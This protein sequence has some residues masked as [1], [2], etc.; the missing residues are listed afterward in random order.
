MTQSMSMR[1]RIAVAIGALRG[2]DVIGEKAI[3][4]FEKKQGG[5]AASQ[6]MAYG[7]AKAPETKLEPL[8]RHGWRKNEL[9]FT[10][11][12]K[13]ADTT[14]Q[15]ALRVHTKKDQTEL[16]EHPLRRLLARPNP[17]MT[18]SL[19][20]G[21]VIILRDFAGNCY[22]EKVRSRAGRTVQLWPMRPD[23]VK[24]HHDKDGMP[25]G[26]FYT[27]PGLSPIFYEPEDVVPFRLWDPLNEY[28]GYPPVAV[29]SRIGDMDN[30]TT[31]YVRLIF[32]KGGVPPG[33]LT[34]TQPLNE[35]VAQRIRQMYREQYGGYE[36]WD[37]PMVLGYDTKYQSTGL[38]FE[39]MG[40]EIL[41]SRAETRICMVLK[42]S[43][44]LVGG[45]FGLSRAIQ[46]NVKEY[47]RNW[48]D[49]DL[50][51]LYKSFA[52]VIRDHL[53]PEFGSGIDVGWDFDEVPALQ[54][55]R[56]TKRKSALEA[57]RASAITRNQFNVEWGLPDL[58]PRGDVYV[59]SSLQVEV[60]AKKVKDPSPAKPDDTTP[61]DEPAE[62]QE[63]EDDGKGLHTWSFSR[64]PALLPPT[65]VD[66]LKA[67]SRPDEF[68]AAMRKAEKRIV[69]AMKRYLGGLKRRVVAAVREQV[70][71]H[72]PKSNRQVKVMV[73]DDVFWNDERE[74]LY[75]VLFPLFSSIMTD[76]AKDAYEELAGMT[77]LGTAWDV[78]NEEAIAWADQHTR[79]VVG[80]ISKTSMDG[81][82]TEFE[83]WL[84][85]G[86]PLPDLIEAL[87]QY[88]GPVRADMVGVTE[89]TR[90]FALANIGT[91]R[92]FSDLVTGFDVI[93]A[94]DADVEEICM[95]E[96]A[97]NPHKL[98]DP[99][100]PYHV[101]CRCAVRPVVKL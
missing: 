12:S 3:Q 39:E 50:I 10:C 44:V 85:S 2:V 74:R 71:S 1:E 8:I 54:E 79:D 9:I 22:F 43:P 51:P 78:I 36:K 5:V 33:I 94:E 14:A 89:C 56:D 86:A 57:F 76:Q 99:P 64:L 82:L 38:G 29:A 41:D 97:S 13:K 52:D 17:Y 73:I 34:S 11:V 18:E 62:D 53:L 40:L 72:R 45:Q 21:C 88:Y 58:G 84:N 101:R 87:E 65:F 6:V 68:Q 4:E 35:T 47:Q 61:D 59:M 100:P 70:T 90:A 98:D 67:I 93:T 96:Q 19:F 83:P 16:E 95:A 15:V 66:D 55:D 60:P 7:Q 46:A 28:F 24:I 92:E 75:D 49:N 69:D 26:Y 23:W 42:V 31:D 30:S 25:D 77:E 80:Q 91:W 27:V 37:A 81:F 63:P 48:W 32:E 20:W